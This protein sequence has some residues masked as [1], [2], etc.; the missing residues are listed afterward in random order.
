MSSKRKIIING[1]AVTD[2]VPDGGASVPS[3]RKPAEIRAEWQAQNYLRITHREAA[4]RWGPMTANAI[5][6][7]L[8]EGIETTVLM[9]RSQ[10]RE[11][12]TVTDPEVI[13]RLVAQVIR[14]SVQAGKD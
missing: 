12:G 9:S 1:I 11:L 5:W 13:A 8:G 10:Y 14:Q 7:G 6:K 3:S 4:G 2:I